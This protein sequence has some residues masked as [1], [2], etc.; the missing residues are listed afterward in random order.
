MALKEPEMNNHR[1]NRG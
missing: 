1:C